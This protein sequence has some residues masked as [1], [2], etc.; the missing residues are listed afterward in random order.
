[1]RKPLLFAAILLAGCAS[2]RGGEAARD[3]VWPLTSLSTIG[4]HTPQVLGNP[5]VVTEGGRTAICFDGRHDGLLLPMNPIE[6]WPRFT[7]EVTFRPDADGPAEQRFL[8]IEDDAGRRAL[9]E[10]RVNDDGAWAL[11]TFLHASQAERLTLLDRAI[12][13]PTDRWYRVALVYDGRTMSHRVDGRK[14]LEGAVVFPPMS[15]GRVSLGVRQNLVHWF[16]GC[17]AEV[18]F[19]P[20]ADVSSN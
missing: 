13:Q 20:R 11:D 18:R 2:P 8:H 12:V 7:I 16:K 5:R 6:G 17:I 1:M 14:Q 15:A 10:T 9:L 4:G 3:I 19:R